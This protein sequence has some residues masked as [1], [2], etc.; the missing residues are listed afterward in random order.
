MTPTR[1]PATNAVLTYAT[2]T[3]AAHSAAN[4]STRMRA[5][6]VHGARVDRAADENVVSA[7]R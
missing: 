7:A 5:R 4:S 2:R 6:G 1:L 3:G